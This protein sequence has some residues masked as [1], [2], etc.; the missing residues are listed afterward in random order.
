MPVEILAPFTLDVTGQIA[1]TS[2]PRVQAQQHIESLVSTNPG[3]RV[4]L[5][6]YGVPLKTYLFEPGEN[7]V[8][9]QM[10]KDITAQMTQWEPGINV[11]G[12]TPVPN[13]QPGL[14]DVNVDWEFTPNITAALQTAIVQVGGTV[15][16]D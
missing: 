10:V 11:L 7:I 8:D 14:A 6:D 1:T 4:M 15:V 5:P 13:N 2:D 16:P 9:Q 12:I 3:E